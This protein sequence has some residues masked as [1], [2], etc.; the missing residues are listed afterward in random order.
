PRARSKP[1]ARRAFERQDGP[2]GHAPRVAGLGHRSP[3]AA[4]AKP[5][6]AAEIERV[7]TVFVAR[8]LHKSRARLRL[9]SRLRP[10]PHHELGETW[11]NVPRRGDRLKKAREEPIERVARRRARL[12]VGLKGRARRRRELVG[13]LEHD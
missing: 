5:N 7:E 12:A 4:G 6:A 13:V 8:N 10:T 3:A 9:V 1:L 11:P 2:F